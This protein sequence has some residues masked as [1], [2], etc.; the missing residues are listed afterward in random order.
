MFDILSTLL[1][2]DEAPDFS[3]ATSRAS[4]FSIK[5][6]MKSSA[7]KKKF[8][9]TIEQPPSRPSSAR[10]KKY[11]QDSPVGHP[12]HLSLA[13]C[14]SDERSDSFSSTY[15]S[16]GGR[17]VEQMRA[18]ARRQHNRSPKP[19]P[20]KIAQVQRYS[21]FEVIDGQDVLSPEELVSPRQR[22]R[23]EV[24]STPT[25]YTIFQNILQVHV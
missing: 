22:Q 5:T 13:R 15:S 9:S 17:S 23:P 11:S 25:L 21:D 24:G 19:R 2:D 8:A 4:R 18:A 10:D 16:E 6:V 12:K 3:A 7:P 20:R 1:D 14:H